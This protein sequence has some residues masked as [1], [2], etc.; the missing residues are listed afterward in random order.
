MNIISISI[1]VYN[2]APYLTEA[3]ESIVC[4]DFSNYEILLINDGSTDA[5]PD[6]CGK[7]CDDYARQDSRIVVLHKENGGLSDARNVGLDICKG[8]CISF[9]DS[10]DFVHPRFIEV[11][12]E[13]LAVNNA[14]VSFGRYI[15]YSDLI[16]EKQYVKTN[17]PTSIFKGT[18]FIANMFAYNLS[19]FNVVVWNKL[20]KREL[21]TVHRFSKGFNLKDE[22]IFTDI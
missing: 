7:I 9:I 3:I 6:N 13:N 21:F 10:D 12:Y 18:E 17:A 11:F 8:D 1:P 15:L 5:S 4:Q 20:Y 2:V 14:D 19:S 22:P 16:G